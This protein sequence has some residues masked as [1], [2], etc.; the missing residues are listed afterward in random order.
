MSSLADTQAYLRQKRATG[1]LSPDEIE[2]AYT[3]FYQNESNQ[4]LANARQDLDSRRVAINESQTQQRIDQS[5][6]QLQIQERAERDARHEAELQGRLQFAKMAVPDLF[7]AGGDT[8]GGAQEATSQAVGPGGSSD[9]SIG[10]TEQHA[11]GVP[12]TD[13][14][15]LDGVDFSGGKTL[16]GMAK[17]TVG[18]K[19]QNAGIGV[20]AGPKGMGA[21]AVAR[22]LKE[23]VEWGL[24][25]LGD[26]FGALFSFGDRQDDAMENDFAGFEA[27]LGST[28][29]SEPGAGYT[30]H[31]FGDP[32]DV[33]G[34]SENFGQEN[35]GEVAV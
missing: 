6:R 33:G 8:T 23:I 20:I 10:T 7:Q 26:M 2:S 19:E 32:G 30:G 24:N 16:S 22:G 5:N 3:G 11:P 1:R 21:A 31:G 25:V 14:G 29:E 27:G 35:L 15:L 12:A 4:M 9:G 13:V 34:A 17:A 28:G 18:T